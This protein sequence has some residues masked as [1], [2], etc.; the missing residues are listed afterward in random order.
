MTFPPAATIPRGALFGGN[1]SE[2][3]EI[4]KR[5]KFDGRAHS[6]PQRCRK[7]NP[8]NVSSEEDA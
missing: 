7:A 8:A 6:G 2:N 4:G 1:V 5:D 3:V